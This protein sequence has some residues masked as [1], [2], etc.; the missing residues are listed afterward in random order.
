M[1][2]L[3]VHI[4]QVKL[5]NEVVLYFEPISLHNF[6]LTYHGQMIELI[7]LESEVIRYLTPIS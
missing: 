3:T 7:I 6:C 4:L 1:T 5:T 2:S